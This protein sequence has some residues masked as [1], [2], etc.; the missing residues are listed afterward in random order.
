M[1]L[2]GNIILWGLDL[3]SISMIN[4]VMA[5]GL[6]IDYSMHMAHNFSLQNSALSRK[7]RAELAVREMG[8]PIFLGVCTTFLAILPLGFSS[9]QAFRVFFK[10][11]FGI[12]LAG[13]AHGLIFLPVLLSFMGPTMSVETDSVEAISNVEDASKKSANAE[14]EEIKTQDVWTVMIMIVKYIWW[15]R[16]RRY[17]LKGTR[18]VGQ[19]LSPELACKTH[20]LWFGWTAFLR[21]SDF[22]ADNEF[23]IVWLSGIESVHPLFGRQFPL[24]VTP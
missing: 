18:V 6:V 8:Q 21:L 16:S 12:V 1:D 13:G 20:V 11:F 3:N 17:V 2:I 9:S 5:V 15:L 10:M 22:I 7:K 23:L 4:L 24:D 14:K 19:F